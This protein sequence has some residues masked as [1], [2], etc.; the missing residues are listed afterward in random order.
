MMH[1]NLTRRNF[2]GAT[3]AV[4]AAFTIVPRAVLGGPRNI[5]P[6]EKMNVAG[7]G[8]GG[9]GAG[10]LRNLES[11][12]IVA[13]CD[14]DHGYA[15][16]TFKRYA[17]VKTYKDYREM[18]EKQ[19]DIDAVLMATPDHTHA[20]IA[21]AAMKAGKHVYCQKPLTHDVYEARML[22][23]AAKEAKVATQ[24]GI[25]GHSGEGARLINEWV[26]AGLIGEVREV[27]AWCSLSYYPWG[28]AGW[29]SKYS[30]RPADTPPVPPTLDWD[31]W[32]G[33]A[34]MRPYHPAYHPAVWRCWWDFGCGMMGDRGAHTFDPVVWALKLGAPTSV[35]ATSCGNTMEVHPLSAIVTFRFPARGDLPPVKLTWYEGTRPPRPDDLEQNR[36]MPDEG[37]ALIKGSKGTILFGVY[38]DSPRIIPESKMK[39]LKLP[40]KTIPRV[41]GSHE[42]D[43]VR[44]CKSGQPAGA[45]FAYSG[46]LT[47]TCLLGNVA[48]RIDGR[49][50]WDAANLRVTNSPE[51][52]QVVRTEYRK[53]WNL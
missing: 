1:G 27:D 47:E 34:S 26:T 42:M 24:M 36:K 50:E 32:I 17:G 2:L 10:N 11:E 22:A 21:M 45:D 39:E 29:S 5:P 51:A 25:Q 19:R 14:V 37:G 38:G 15:A 4:A 7:I 28:H 46:P 52:N 12:N 3:A 53:G 33:P 20:V 13:L 16:K 8:V 43:W 35:E 6:S 49:I 18:L 30:A 23:Q 40:E 31:L 48:K 41:N 9:M 44:A